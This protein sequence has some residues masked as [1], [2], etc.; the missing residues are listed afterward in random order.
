M[1]QQILIHY[2]LL[3]RMPKSLLLST[4]FILFSSSYVF[5]QNFFAFSSGISVDIGNEGRF[6]H[7]PLSLQYGTLNSKAGAL[8]VKAEIGLPLVNKSHDMAYTAESGLPQEIAVQK[9]ISSYY[10]SAMV[11]YRFYL[12]RQA[13]NKFF[14][15][16]L[17]LGIGWQYFEVRY[18][19][20]DNTNYEV[21]NPDI[22]VDKIGVFATGGAGYLSNHFLFQ[23]HIQSPILTSR[24]EYKLSF[25]S[26]ANLQLTIGY[27]LNLPKNKR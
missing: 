23:L 7:I 20:Y 27:R 6:K 15:D 26:H 13:P 14:I 5:A 4:V 8:I 9:N 18:K 12:N 21:L 2:C 22:S 25:E 24:Q 10:T 19:N 1:Q 17:P 11:G 16:L 3:I